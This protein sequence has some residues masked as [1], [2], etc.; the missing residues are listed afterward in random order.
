MRPELQQHLERCLRIR[1]IDKSWVYGRFALSEELRQNY[2]KA[3]YCFKK[4]ILASQHDEKIKDYRQD[5]ERCQMK[6]EIWKRH[7]VRVEPPTEQERSDE[8]R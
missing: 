4:A 2:E 1:T 6:T 7:A 3:I 8:V 5:I